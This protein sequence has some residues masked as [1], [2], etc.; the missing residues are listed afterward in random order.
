MALIYGRAIAYITG[1]ETP[2]L[3]NRDFV[4]LIELCSEHSHDG[5]L[6]ELVTNTGAT[7]P[8]VDSSGATLGQIIDLKLR[9]G[10]RD[11]PARRVTGIVDLTPGGKAAVRREL[12]GLTFL[13]PI[14]DENKIVRLELTNGDENAARVSR[15]V[16]NPNAA[17]HADLF[18][19]L[20]WS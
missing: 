13:T 14:F 3:T 7:I 11:E 18:K 4:K 20:G 15:P 19:R 2:A 8:I 10:T 17:K 5:D 6:S 12:P 16:R 9:E 1:P